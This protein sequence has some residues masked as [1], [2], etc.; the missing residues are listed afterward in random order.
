MVPEIKL[1]QGTALALEIT[2]Q[3]LVK[4]TGRVKVRDAPRQ[5]QRM[6]DVMEPGDFAVGGVEKRNTVLTKSRVRFAQPSRVALG[7]REDI[8]RTD[9]ELLRL[10][11]RDWGTP[12]MKN[13]VGRSVLGGVLLRSIRANAR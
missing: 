10:D 8:L 5:I 11:D 13:V 3:S 2:A 7:L 1:A 6:P 12:E 4:G 9:R